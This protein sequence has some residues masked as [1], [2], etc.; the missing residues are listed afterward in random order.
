MPRL[1]LSG[2]ITISPGA[3]VSIEKLSETHI[4]PSIFNLLKLSAL[5]MMGMV[6]ESN[7]YTWAHADDTWLML[8]TIRTIPF[9]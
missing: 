8:R 4:C 6:L 5:E 7:A 1:V 2:T 3:S 9:S